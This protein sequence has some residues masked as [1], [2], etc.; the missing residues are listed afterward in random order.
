MHDIRAIRDNPDAFDAAMAKRGI[1]GASAE[2]LA[3]DGSRRA[4]IAAAEAAQ[5]DRNAASKEVGAAKA[6]GDDAE[7]ERLRAVVSAKKDEISGLESEA[8]SEDAR[9]RDV[10]M[11]LPNIVYD[12]V[13]VGDNEDDNVEI[14][15][16]GEP[17]RFEFEPKE[18]FDIEG[19]KPGMDFATAAKM[20]GSRFVLMSGAIA[21]L[22]RALDTL[23]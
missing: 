3:I 5:A 16:W 19:V 22:H 9:L 11:S 21:R 8:K 7:F 15:R 18:H 10:L 2:I 13:P 23:E 14:S 4:R 17:C 1:S 12:D 20:S 6:G